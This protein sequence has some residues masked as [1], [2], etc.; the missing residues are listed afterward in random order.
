MLARKQPQGK[1][2]NGGDLPT[3]VK[4]ARKH[5]RVAGWSYRDAADELGVHYT[6]LGLVLTARR[7][8]ARLLAR[9]LTLPE[10]D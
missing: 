10:R 6:H 9:V 3:E 2:G 8:S 7:V 1:N 4:R 5:L